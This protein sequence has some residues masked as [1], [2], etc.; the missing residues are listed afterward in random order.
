METVTQSWIDAHEQR[1]LPEGVI[2]VV[3]GRTD[4]AQGGAIFSPNGTA[5]SDI[6]EVM[7]TTPIEDNGRF[8]DPSGTWLLDGNTNLLIAY[9]T[10]LKKTVDIDG[11]LYNFPGYYG[12]V[13]YPTVNVSDQY[14]KIPGITITWSTTFDEFAIDYDVVAYDE[15]GSVLSTLTVTGNTRVVDYRAMENLQGYS[16][17]EIIVSRWSLPN[18]YTKIERIRL[19]YE[20]EF[21]KKDLL[22]FSFKDYCSPNSLTLPKSSIAFEVY[23]RNDQW[24]PAN[25]NGLYGLLSERLPVKVNVGNIIGGDTQT[26]PLGMFYLNGWDTPQN[27]ISAKFEARDL[28]LFMDRK[29]DTANEYDSDG[30]ISST[31]SP[32]YDSQGQPIQFDSDPYNYLL[33][34]ALWQ[35]KRAGVQDL[36]DGYAPFTYE[37]PTD[38]QSVQFVLPIGFDFTIGEVIQLVANACRCIIHQNREGYLTILPYN[39]DSQTHVDYAIAQSVSY[40]YAEYNLQKQCAQVVVT[41]S[42]GNEL[43]EYPAVAGEGEIQTVTNPILTNQTLALAQAQ[44]IYAVLSKRNTVYGSWRADPR[45]DLLDVIELENKYATQNVMLTEIEYTSNGVLQGSY[46]GRV[47]S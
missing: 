27:G 30:N 19:G 23:N 44:W 12:R 47:V 5:L 34:Q 10:S 20:L 28:L 36:D 22:S 32:Y 39:V 6:S 21:G 17:I 40:R 9:P 16:T 33:E 24:N 14:V 38:T 2:S 15:G 8:A 1:I 41:D 4:P 42:N 13:G 37:L 46:K 43:A 7:A 31:V 26:I 45:V 35:A 11:E 25:P 18:G 29:F 3:L